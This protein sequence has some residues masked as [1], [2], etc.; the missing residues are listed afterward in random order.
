VSV[1]ARRV[2][3]SHMAPGELSSGIPVAAGAGWPTPAEHQVC[4]WAG[5]ECRW[6]PWAGGPLRHLDTRSRP[7][8]A[9]WSWSVAP[10]GVGCDHAATA[11]EPTVGRSGDSGEWPSLRWVVSDPERHG[12]FGRNDRAGDHQLS[13]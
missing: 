3:S 10:S 2:S 6:P 11:G 1:A 5:R 12:S 4:L 13:V 7:A 8:V 9:A